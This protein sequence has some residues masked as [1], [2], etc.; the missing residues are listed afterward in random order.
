M[1]AEKYALKC[2]TLHSDD[3]ERAEA[4]PSFNSVGENIFAAGG[5]TLMI[6]Y[7][8]YI[9]GTWGEE[10][11]YYD[12]NLNSCQP[13]KMCGHYTQV[14]IKISSLLQTKDCLHSRSPF[15]I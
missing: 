12:Y 11:A 14:S 7:T 15:V 1:E 13:G 5:T 8:S 3:E 4:A 9:V 6:D 10:K 2:S